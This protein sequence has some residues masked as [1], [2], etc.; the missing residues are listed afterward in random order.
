MTVDGKPGT[1]RGANPKGMI[2]YD[3]SGHMAVHVAPERQEPREPLS[4]V[5]AYFGTYAIDES[6]GTVTHHKQA[7]VQPGDAGDVV[8]G[9]EFAGDRLILRPIEAKNTQII[10]ERIK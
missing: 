1:E 6:A 9:Y 5:V 2:L 7:S 8:R 3:P 10:W 4:G